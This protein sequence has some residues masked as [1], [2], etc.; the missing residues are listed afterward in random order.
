VYFTDRNPVLFTGAL[1]V[2]DIR[3]GT[4]HTVV[5]KAL[6]MT[7]DGL[8]SASRVGVSG[9]WGVAA[10]PSGWLAWTETDMDALR[11][12]FRSDSPLCPTG[13]HHSDDDGGK[14]VRCPTHPLGLDYIGEQCRW[15]CARDTGT[16]FLCPESFRSVVVP[17][18]MALGSLAGRPVLVCAD[19]WE[20][21]MGM[22]GTTCAVHQ[23]TLCNAGY[24]CTSNQTLQCPAI[25]DGYSSGIGAG[26]LQD[27]FD[28]YTC[29]AGYYCPSGTKQDET[30]CPPH[31][32]S[33]AGS[34]SRLGCSCIMGY[35]EPDA[36]EGDGICCQVGS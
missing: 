22:D 28:V 8:V 32:D 29:Q 4:V 10:S 31:M 2:W 18:N 6:R 35:Y 20:G 16:P 3:M 14:C 24:Y 30:S 12:V 34:T 26:E 7:E 25:Q 23:C 19:G 36:Y 5:G 27:C 21:C 9:I 13:Y 33:R 1:R 11:I 15:R 17:E